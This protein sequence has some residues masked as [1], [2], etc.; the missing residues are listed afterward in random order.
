MKISFINQITEAKQII[1][2]LHDRCHDEQ[3]E[4]AST[5]LQCKWAIDKVY[6]T[7]TEVLDRDA[8]EDK[9]YRPPLKEIK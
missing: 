5:I 2:L 9:S 3:S 1:D 6:H 8:N 4:F 7:Y